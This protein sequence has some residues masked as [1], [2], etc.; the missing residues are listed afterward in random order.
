MQDESEVLVTNLMGT[1][2]TVEE[3]EERN[4]IKAVCDLQ[5]N[6]LYFTREPIRPRSMIDNIPM[7][8]QLCIIPFRHDFLLEYARMVLTPLEIVGSVDMI[9][10]LEHGMKVRMVPIRYDTYAV[11]TLNDLS[12][13]ENLRRRISDI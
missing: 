4:S 6:A 1:M 12:F 7:G 5:D 8:K 13:V 11:D 10:I 9:R 3:F 2:K